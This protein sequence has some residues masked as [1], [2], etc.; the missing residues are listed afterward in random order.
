MR[1]ILVFSFFS[2]FFSTF[3]AQSFLSTNA[4][5]VGDNVTLYVCD[6]TFSNYDADNGSNVTWDFSNITSMDGETT[7]TLS[8]ESNLNTDFVN[9]SNVSSIPSFLETYW[10]SSSSGKSSQGFVYYTNDNAVGN[11]KVKFNLDEEKLIDFPF[12]LNSSLTDTYNGVFINDA[13]ASNGAPCSGT[14]IS[15]IDAKGT[16]ILPGNNTYSDVL[17]HKVEETTNS[18][19]NL[20]FFGPTAVTVIRKQFDY[21]DLTTNNLPLF[22]HIYISYDAGGVLKD[23]ITLVLSTIDPVAE[24][25]T[26]KIE[27]INSSFQINIK[28]NPSKGSFQLSGDFVGTAKLNIIDPNGREIMSYQDVSSGEVIDVSELFPGLYYV[29]VLNDGNSS[30]IKLKVD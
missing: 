30:I 16:L 10:N 23:N 1:L 28:P 5:Q 2:L 3:L 8:V 13:Y 22:S 20:P 24:P 26:A 4:A 17:R 12:S 11:F 15:K 25:N 27:S 21:Y 6:D 9:A 7:K 29:R 18:T 14:I 19:I